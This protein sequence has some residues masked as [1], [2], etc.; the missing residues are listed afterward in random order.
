MYLKLI[1]L[2]IIFILSAIV[3]GTT[4]KVKDSADTGSQAYKDS[5]TAYN[6]ATGV[7]VLSLLLIGMCVWKAMSGSSRYGKYFSL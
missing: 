1:A 7:L 4:A 3:M 5:T 2:I 6:A